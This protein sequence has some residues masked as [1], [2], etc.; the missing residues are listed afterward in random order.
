M[1]GL[2]SSNVVLDVAVGQILL[3]TDGGNASLNL[4]LEQSGDL[5]VWT[6]AGA[7]L[8]WV[9]PVD[10]EKKFYRVRSRK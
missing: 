8:E 7:V 5:Q 4:Q 3:E 6:N 10:G 2:Y 9:L 1:F